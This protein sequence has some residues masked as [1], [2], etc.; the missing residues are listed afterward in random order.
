MEEEGVGEPF[1][2][3]C[4][5]LE[6]GVVSEEYVRVEFIA[7]GRLSTGFIAINAQTITERADGDVSPLPTGVVSSSK[8]VDGF[9]VWY[10]EGNHDE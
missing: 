6:F 1:S 3:Y 2:D 4:G 10:V 7:D 9:E 5:Y 8:E